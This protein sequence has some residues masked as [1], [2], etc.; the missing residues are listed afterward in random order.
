MRIIV[1]GLVLGLSASIAA[2]KPMQIITN[3]EGARCTIRQEGG[4]RGVVDHT[5]GVAQIDTRAYGLRVKCTKKGFWPAE[6][7]IGDADRRFD[8]PETMFERLEIARDRS[9]LRRLDVIR[10][11]LEEK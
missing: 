7:E 11:T 4:T 8:P 3:P 2:A 10:L 5:P 9:R 1:V 6:Y